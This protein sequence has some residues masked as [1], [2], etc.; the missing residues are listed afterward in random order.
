VKAPRIMGQVYR[1]IL[2]GMIARGWSPPRERVSVPRTRLLWI[3]L[4]Y[5]FI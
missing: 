2:D 1:L 3:I 5:A 4:R